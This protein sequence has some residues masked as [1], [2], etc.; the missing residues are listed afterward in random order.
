MTTTKTYT[1]ITGGTTGIGYELAKIFAEEAHNLILV[2]R[3]EADL[4]Q[5]KTDLEGAGVDI[6]TIV[7]DL[8][9]PNAAFELY[10]EIRSQHLTVDILVNN[11]GQGEYGLFADTDIKRELAIIQLNISS[12]TILTKLF[13]QDMLERG[14][15]KILN[16]SS[17]ASKTP[18]PWQAVYH[19]TKAFVQ[20]FTEAVRSEVKE[21]NII[22]TALL[23][24]ATD[25][26]FFHKAGMESSKAVQDESKL[27]D[28]A[29]VARDGYDA[30]MN[31]DDKVISGLKNKL[32][33]T[34]SNLM[35][36]QK[37]ADT[38]KKQQEPVTPK[39]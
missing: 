20:S 23:P 35:S 19:G 29:Q 18:G 2:A 7:K 8:F 10:E 28:P 30:L 33:V 39:K 17:I 32:T 4:Q 24:G 6:I 26:D 31:G 9:E 22:I 14:E 13:L 27:S 25:T 5:A 38:M 12:L 11:A 15:G 34:A 37:A 36:D 1:L 21:H 16:L 3:T